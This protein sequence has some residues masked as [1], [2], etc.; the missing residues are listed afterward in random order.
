[1]GYDVNAL[2]RT[3]NLACEAPDAILLVS[4]H[5][6]ASGIVPSHYVHKTGFETGFAAVAFFLIDFNAGTHA[7]S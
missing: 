4:N 1:V 2:S 6:F 5:R 3:V 7:S